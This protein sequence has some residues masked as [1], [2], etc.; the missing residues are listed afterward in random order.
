MSSVVA[1]YY[2]CSY[3][4]VEYLVGK[5]CREIGLIN[6]PRSISPYK[7]RYE[8]YRDAVREFDLEP[9]CVTS[10]S[11]AEP[12]NFEFGYR[13]AARLLDEH[14]GL[15][16]IMAAVDI[17]GMGALRVLHERGVRC[18]D[19]VRVISLTGHSI[20]RMLETTMTSMEVP[21]IEM[22]EKAARMAVEAIETPAGEPP[23]RQH[24]VFSPT[25]VVRD[26]A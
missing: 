21:A 11:T 23:A 6:S 17:Q 24:L 25:L 1:D 18:P 19:D 12:N 3:E 2:S 5:G 4:A 15:D 26:S 20:G 9:I 14:P 13:G 8:G 10:S 22:G 16:A 7:R